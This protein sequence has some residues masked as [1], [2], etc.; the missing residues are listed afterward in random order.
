MLSVPSGFLYSPQQTH[1]SLA[2]G[3]VTVAA[4]V[5]PKN[6]D[7][8]DA[9]AAAQSVT[10]LTL[11]VG[12]ASGG[13]YPNAFPLTAAEVSAGLAA[14]NFSGTLQSIGEALGPGTYFAVATATNLGGTSGSSPEA[15]FQVPSPPTA[16]TALS[17]S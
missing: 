10:G 12:T 5:N 3:R 9:V 14:G 15:S 17:F 4:V 2:A 8:V 13:P 7:I 16:P 1:V 6:F 11:L